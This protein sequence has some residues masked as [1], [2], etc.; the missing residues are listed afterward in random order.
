MMRLNKMAGIIGDRAFVPLTGRQLFGERVD[1]SV[2]VVLGIDGANQRAISAGDQIVD[3]ALAP[4]DA[5]AFER[6]GVALRDQCIGQEDDAVA[7]VEL[8]GQVV[9]GAFV[10]VRCGQT[11]AAHSLSQ[12]GDEIMRTPALR[13]RALMERP[14]ARAGCELRAR[15]RPFP[16]SSASCG[17]DPHW[18]R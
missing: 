12:L 2:A 1:D 8:L 10:D 3:E 14:P 18:R 6:V 9:A 7:G 15:S 13:A 4:H 16:A 5:D 11:R 17:G